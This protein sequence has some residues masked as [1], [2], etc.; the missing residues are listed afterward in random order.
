M[1]LSHISIFLLFPHLYL[2]ILGKSFI[3]LRTSDLHMLYCGRGWWNGEE[4]KEEWKE[5]QGRKEREVMNRV[6]SPW[7]EIG[8][9]CR[10]RDGD[11]KKR[12]KIGIGLKTKTMRKKNG[13]KRKRMTKKTGRRFRRRQRKETNWRPK[14]SEVKE[15]RMKR[16]E[17][18]KQRR[19]SRSRDGS[20]F[21]NPNHS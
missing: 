12:K 16:T 10:C 3:Y 2:R 7:C 15:E 14:R 4:E 18:R 8:G 21:F 19:Q 17:L 20:D 1:R 6:Y 11:K 5:S 13:K 9:E